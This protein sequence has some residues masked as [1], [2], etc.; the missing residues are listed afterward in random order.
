[1]KVVL[2]ILLVLVVVA[3]VEGPLRRL[4]QEQEGRL[5]QL[6]PLKVPQRQLVG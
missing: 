1:V 5:A 2:V 4:D 3:V 6:V